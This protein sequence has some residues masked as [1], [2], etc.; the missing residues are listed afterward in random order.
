MNS[1]PNVCIQLVV[2]ILHIPLFGTCRKYTVN[3]HFTA[4]K[5]SHAKTTD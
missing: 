4:I 3:I 1:Y 5:I 2:V